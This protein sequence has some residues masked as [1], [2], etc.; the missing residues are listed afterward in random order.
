MSKMKDIVS[1]ICE[2]HA[3]GFK[4]IT[5]AALLKQPVEVVEEVIYDYQREYEEAFRSQVETE[6]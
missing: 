5:I 1:D 2:L 3:R 6:A 4:T